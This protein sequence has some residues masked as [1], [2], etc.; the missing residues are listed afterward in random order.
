MVLRKKYLLKMH[1][2]FIKWDVTWNYFFEVVLMWN[3]LN[4]LHM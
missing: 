1:L 4:L 3:Y 2:K